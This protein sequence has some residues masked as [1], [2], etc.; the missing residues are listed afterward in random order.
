[1]YNT[2]DGASSDIMKEVFQFCEESNC[3]LRHASQFTI[4][5][6]NIAYHGTKSGYFLAPKSWEFIPTHIV[7]LLSSL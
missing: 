6:I 4:P 1:M 5:C 7:V 2:I 3:K